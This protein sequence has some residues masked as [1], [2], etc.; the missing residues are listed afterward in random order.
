[1][2]SYVRLEPV[3]EAFTR[4]LP[5]CYC[6]NHRFL[7]LDRRRDLESVQY[8]H[9]FHRGVSDALVSVDERVIQ[10]ERVPERSRLCDEV[11]LQVL[12]IEGHFRTRDGGFQAIAISDAGR[13][14]RLNDHHRVQCEVVVELEINH[15]D[16]RR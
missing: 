5:S 15:H 16:R 12:A 7:L 9:Y 2:L 8:K 11:R 1:M 13:P 4:H 6:E 14:A 10:H 3:S